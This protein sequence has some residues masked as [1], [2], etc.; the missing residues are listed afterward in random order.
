MCCLSTRCSYTQVSAFLVRLL[1]GLS[2]QVAQSFV[3]AGRGALKSG[4]LICPIEKA[5]MGQPPVLEGVCTLRRRCAL[6]EVQIGVVVNRQ[7]SPSNLGTRTDI[8]AVV[9]RK[10]ENRK[11]IVATPQPSPWW[12]RDRLNGS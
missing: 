9:R 5:P 7:D 8:P 11:E 12:Q 6:C 2:L 3:V 1:V 4:E 10:L